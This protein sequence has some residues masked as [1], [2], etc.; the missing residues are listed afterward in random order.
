MSRWYR[1]DERKPEDELPA[2][3]ESVKVLV[4]FRGANN[5]WT[6]RTETRVFYSSSWRG[7]AHW[8]W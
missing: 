1:M 3:K 7:P 6:M 8:D 4:A 5:V 2:D